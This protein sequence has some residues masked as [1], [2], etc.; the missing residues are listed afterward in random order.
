MP[1]PPGAQ[2]PTL[3]MVPGGSPGGFRAGAGP[4]SRHAGFRCQWALLHMFTGHPYFISGT[5]PVQAFLPFFPHCLVHI[6]L[7][8]P[9]CIMCLETTQASACLVHT[10]QIH[11]LRGT[12]TSDTHLNHVRV[13]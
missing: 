10:D 4:T 3:G 5:K 1:G 9:V 11:I 6:G 2:V 12:H 8:G 13:Q 7:Q